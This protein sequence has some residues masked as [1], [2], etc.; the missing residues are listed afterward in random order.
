VGQDLTAYLENE[1]PVEERLIYSESLLPTLYDCSSLLGL[2]GDRWKYIQSSA[3]EMYDL[4]K[5]PGETKNRIEPEAKRARVFQEEL[6]LILTEQARTTASRS[7]ESMNQETRQ[8]LESL[9]YVASSSVR[10][11]FEFD[12]NKDIPSDWLNTHQNLLLFSTF[13]KAGL[14]DQA[15]EA[16]LKVT[17]EKPVYIPAYF[18]LAETQYNLGMYP[19]AI[20]A[21]NKFLEKIGKSSERG[22]NKLFLEVALKY[23]GIAYNILGLSYSSLQEY[24][25]AF[26]QFE[27]ALEKADD[28]ESAKILNNIGIVYR[29]QGKLDKALDYFTKG[30]EFDPHSVESY[31]NSGIV[32]E[33]KKEYQKALSAFKKAHELKPDLIQAKTKYEQMQKILSQ[34]AQV[35]KTVAQDESDLEKSPDSTKLLNRL[36]GSHL[37][38]GN[39]DK[40]IAYWE[41]CLLTKPDNPDV[42]NN[43]AFIYAEKKVSHTFDSDKALDY[44]KKA[45]NL[46]KHQNPNFLDTLASVHAAR[47]E[48]DQAVDIAQQAMNIAISSNQ[49][50][51]AESIQKNIEHYQNKS[52][53]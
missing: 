1:S 18:Y 13:K 3:P 24:D 32:Q 4:D 34:R 30:L 6:K 2:T 14:F 25:K 35:R 31:Y 19:E 47:G 5:D 37:F 20:S 27:K 28:S 45:C 46:T 49:L 44:A 36:A 52:L 16:A 42:L 11:D 33:Q 39:R 23:L 43:L 38:L 21:G 15:K 50:T 48:F 53:P 22:E 12:T 40:A 41:K 7:K 51:L 17:E 26:Q 9:G 8:K 10:E 29:S